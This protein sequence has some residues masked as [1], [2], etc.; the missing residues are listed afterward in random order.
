[1]ANEAIR[2]HEPSTYVTLATS[3]AEGKRDRLK[4][5]SPRATEPP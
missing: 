1:M 4:G 5:A 2:G 3:N